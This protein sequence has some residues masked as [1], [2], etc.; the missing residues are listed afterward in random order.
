[1]TTPLLLIENLRVDFP[2]VMAV[3]GLSLEVQAGEICGLIGPNGAGK[4]T[5]MRAVSGLQECTRGR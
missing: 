4:T 2:A 5:T 1:M 3:D